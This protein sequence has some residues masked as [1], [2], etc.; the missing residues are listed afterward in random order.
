MMVSAPASGLDGAEILISPSILSYSLSNYTEE[1][2]ASIDTL[3]G[4]GEFG[5]AFRADNTADYYSFLWNGNPENAT[6]HWQAVDFAS[7]GIY[8]YLGGSSYGGGIATPIYSPGTWAHF[9]YR[10]LYHPKQHCYN[11]ADIYY[12]RNRYNNIYIYN[13]PYI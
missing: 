2:D 9:I 1:F 8:A 5:S 11:N 7:G 13:F 4:Y 12:N 3:N 10:L 6:P